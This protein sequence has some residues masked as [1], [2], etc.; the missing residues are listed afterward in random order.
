MTFGEKLYK[1][2]KEQ[3][4]SQEA[5]AEKLGATRQAV[6]RWEN[7]QGFPETEKLLMLSSL[8]SVSLD[9]L[10][11]DTPPEQT[12]GNPAEEGYYASRETT[13]GYLAHTQKTAV[14]IGLF[15]LCFFGAALPFILFPQANEDICALG[16]IAF[17]A[18]GIA[19]ALSMAFQTDPYPQME[20]EP[21]FFDHQFL[22]EL[23]ARYGVLR[24][25]YV[26]L[27]IFGFLLI[28]LAGG[29]AVLF[30]DILG[31]FSMLSELIALVCISG[32]VFCWIFSLSMMS[33]YEILLENPK[34]IAS[35][36]KWQQPAYRL[37]T[38]GL[39]CAA[40]IIVVT[41]GCLHKAGILW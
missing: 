28:F 8:F 25:R 19:G 12:E 13:L 3:N 17:V 32:S 6:S 9:Y 7:G 21:L 10:L 36:R 4:L 39:I 29:F 24:K 16:S 15:V 26:W 2:R 14:K 38:W 18:A 1:L 40:V 34:H 41:L 31:K 5:L 22:E 33:A 20:K 35:R 11:K 27:F 37:L 30:D 23:K